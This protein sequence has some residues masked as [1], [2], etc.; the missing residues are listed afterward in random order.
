MKEKLGNQPLQDY[1]E[2]LQD[3]RKWLVSYRSNPSID[4]EERRKYWEEASG[5]KTYAVEKDNRIFII[6]DEEQPLGGEINE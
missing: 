5:F 6:F 4:I 3:T 2:K 1:I